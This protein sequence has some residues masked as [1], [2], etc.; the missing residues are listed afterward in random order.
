MAAEIAQRAEVAT[1]HRRRDPKAVEDMVPF[2]E[3]TWAG[4]FDK[5]VIAGVDHEPLPAQR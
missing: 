3:R 4:R 5:I 1:V 2:L